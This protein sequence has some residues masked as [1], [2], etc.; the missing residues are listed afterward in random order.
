MLDSFFLTIVGKI[1]QR[2]EKNYKILYS[3]LILLYVSKVF[4]L[5]G[6]ALGWMCFGFHA[7]TL[8]HF[9]AAILGGLIGRFLYI[10]VKVFLIHEFDPKHD[11]DE[12]ER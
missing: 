8:N 1:K 11:T 4:P 7:I 3:C 2:K 12:E 10:L 5:I 6:A 9:L